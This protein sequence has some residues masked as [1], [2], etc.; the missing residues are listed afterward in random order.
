M[1]EVCVQENMIEAL[2]RIK[3]NKGAP[4]IDG[5]HVD[6]LPVYLRNHGAAVRDQL[7]KG[8]YRPQPV[9]RVEIPKPDGGMRKLGIPTVL[10][11]FVQQAI[12]QVLERIWDPSFSEHSYGFRPNHSAHQAVAKAQ[13]YIAEGYRY[14]V[15]IDLEKFFDQV[16]HDMLMGR[17]AKRVSDKRM[18]K[19][20][21]AF[22][23]AGVMEDGL[24]SPAEEG[25]PQ[26]GPLSPLLSNIMLDDLDQELEGR[27]HRFVRYADD[28]NIYVHSERAGLRVMESIMRFVTKRLKLKVNQDK[29]KVDRPA[30]RKFLGFSFTSEKEPRRRIASKALKRFKRRVKELT[31]RSRGISIRQMVKE[32]SDYLIGW[33]NYFSYAETPSVLK[34]LDG[35]VRRRLRT[36]HWKQWKQGRTR[37]KELRKRGVSESAA[38][39]AGSSLGPWRIS[40]TKPLHAALSSAYFQSLGLPTLVVGRIA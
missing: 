20:I 25:T 4:G 30:R 32:L 35:W 34:G 8:T 9:K 26:G 12:L 31:G 3:A 16:N 21:R 28:C 27:G 14:V 13:S 10:D 38:E 24:V 39:I 15:D 37:F 33:R 1:E 11:R 6:E 29:S 22:L 2:R 7:L 36:V 19:I 5:M 18:L 40:R 17:V 23:N